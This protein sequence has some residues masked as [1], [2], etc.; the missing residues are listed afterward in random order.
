MHIHTQIERLMKYNHAY[1][2]A[3]EVGSHDEQCDDVTGAQL[4]EGLLARLNRLSDEE[5]LE[6]CG[7]FDTMEAGE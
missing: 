1:D 3:F 4:R 7:N 5:L 6:A 2:F